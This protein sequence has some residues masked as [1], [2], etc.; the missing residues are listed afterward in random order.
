ML[1][2]KTHKELLT[3]Q[4]VGKLV[5]VFVKLKFSKLSAMM[6]NSALVQKWESKWISYT[7]PTNTDYYD[8]YASCMYNRS[9]TQHPHKQ[10]YS[11]V[12]S[13]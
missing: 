7:L 12:L 2:T 6:N 3:I 5:F 10:F 8:D 1:L 13:V 9:G 11:N 4:K